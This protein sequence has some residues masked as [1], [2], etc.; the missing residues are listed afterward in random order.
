ML[1][2]GWIALHVVFLIFLVATVWLTIWQWDRAQEAGGSAQNLGYALQWPLFG[3]FAIYMWIRL[4]RGE[5]TGETGD[6][7][8][9]E[10]RAVDTVDSAEQP[11][12]RA[13]SRPVGRSLVPDRA[14]R[15]SVEEDPELAAYNAYLATLNIADQDNDEQRA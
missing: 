9:E 10:A 15:V 4:I 3:L 1:T 7:E 12:R 8:T 14:R 13:G 6:D 5:Y 2:P 11:L